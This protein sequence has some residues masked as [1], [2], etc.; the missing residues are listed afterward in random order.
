MTAASSG[1]FNEFVVTLDFLPRSWKKRTGSSNLRSNENP[2]H[3][4]FRI[5][6]WDD[7]DGLAMATT[8]CRLPARASASRPSG[9]LLFSAL[10]AA[11]LAHPPNEP[12]DHECGQQERD[13]YAH[14]DEHIGEN[15]SGAVLDGHGA[16]KR[17]ASMPLYGQSSGSP[18]RF[19]H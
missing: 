3:F 1:R 10:F 15:D 19:M 2:D 4:T 18:R 7:D 16:R 8:P 17:S 13:D 6:R 5:D 14:A 12:S 9:R 11:A